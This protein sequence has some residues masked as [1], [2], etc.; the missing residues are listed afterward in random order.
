MNSHLSFSMCLCDGVGGNLLIIS[1]T[2]WQ[3]ERIPPEKHSVADKLFIF[4]F[5]IFNICCFFFTKTGLTISK[6]DTDG[7]ASCYHGTK[8]QL[9]RSA[10]GEA[11]QPQQICAGVS[12]L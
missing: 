5:S 7:G 8:C 6:E 4:Y 3:S 1:D 12:D 10:H 2:Y 9:L 11:S